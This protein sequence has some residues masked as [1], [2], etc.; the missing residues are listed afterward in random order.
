MMCLWTNAICIISTL[1][2]SLENRKSEAL[3]SSQLI[4]S[5]TLARNPPRTGW[6]SSLKSKIQAFCTFITRN[7]LISTLTQ[8]R[9]RSRNHRWLPRQTRCILAW[10]LFAQMITS[11]RR[12]SLLLMNQIFSTTMSRISKVIWT[13]LTMMATT[14]IANFSRGST[15]RW[16]YFN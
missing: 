8:P 9:W 6:R 13:I 4:N 2:S 14:S 5:I 7:V 1:S 12:N 11:N 10:N 3:K 16:I 15:I